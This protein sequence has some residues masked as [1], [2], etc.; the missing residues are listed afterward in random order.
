M[1]NDYILLADMNVEV[2]RIVMF[3]ES[4]QVVAKV[5][6]IEQNLD[7]QFM[8]ARLMGETSVHVYDTTDDTCDAVIL[9]IVNIAV[10]KG[11]DHANV[12]LSGEPVD[13]ELFLEWFLQDRYLE[14]KWKTEEEG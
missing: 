8:A 5:P 2:R 14:W 11:K 12:T 9:E 13:R 6:I 4:F 7:P 10:V 3:K 1:M